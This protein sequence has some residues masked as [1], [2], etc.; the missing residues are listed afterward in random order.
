[1]K[2]HYRVLY[3]V[4]I[5]L[6]HRSVIRHSTSGSRLKSHLPGSLAP[7]ILNAMGTKGTPSDHGSDNDTNSDSGNSGCSE[8]EQDQVK[9]AAEQ[10]EMQPEIEL[11]VD[12]A[13]S[14][15][16]RGGNKYTG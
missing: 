16:L 3:V 6:P 10:P 9:S 1:M 4:T 8:V 15:K 11:P 13:S 12:V 2:T 14:R 7:L 5:L